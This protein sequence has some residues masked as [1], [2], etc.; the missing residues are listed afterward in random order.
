MD[1]D[2]MCLLRIEC[3]QKV[4]GV[5]FHQRLYVFEEEVMS[6]SSSDD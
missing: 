1:K 2:V 4:V 6:L 3:Q 5:S